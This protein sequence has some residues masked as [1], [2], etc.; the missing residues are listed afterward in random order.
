MTINNTILSGRI[1]TDPK[2]AGN[3][4]MPILNFSFAWD[5]FRKGEK[6]SNFIDCSLFGNQAKAL[7]GILKKG[8]LLSVAGRL[9]QQ[10][11]EKDGQIF[12]KHALTIQDVQLPPKDKTPDSEPF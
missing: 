10:S 9:E 11:W 6:Q 8:M 2:K 5:T 4:D 12:Y 1:A 7:S 3:E